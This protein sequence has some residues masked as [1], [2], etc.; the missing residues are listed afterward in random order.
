MW[1]SNLMRSRRPLVKEIEMS[2]KIT[3]TWV[4]AR[5]FFEDWSK[6]VVSMEFEMPIDKGF[7]SDE[8]FCEMV[9]ASTNNYSGHIFQAMQKKGLPEDRNHTALSVGDIVGIDNN[10][11]IV[12]DFGFKKCFSITER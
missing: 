7:Y 11:Y 5:R 9:Y 8:E 3:V 10:Y 12:D 4:P 6:P 1:Y 2:V